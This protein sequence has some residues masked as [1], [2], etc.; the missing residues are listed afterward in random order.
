MEIWKYHFLYDNYMASNLGNIKNIKK[1]EN[2]SGK[3][4]LGEKVVYISYKNNIMTYRFKNFIYEC[5]N[6]IFSSDKYVIY[7]DYNTNNLNIDNLILVNKKELNQFNNTKRNNIISSN[8][9]KNH[10]KYPIGI[11]NESKL[12]YLKGKLK[13]TEI[14]F[15]ETLSELFFLYGSTRLFAKDILYECYNGIIKENH[16]IIYNDFNHKNINIS[17][18]KMIHNNELINYE[19]KVYENKINFKLKDGWKQHP[20]IL[21]YLG[22]EKGE[23][24]SIYKNEIIQGREVGGY[25]IVC[26]YYDTKKINYQ[27]HRFIY[28]CFNGTIKDKLQIDHIDS[29]K[30]NNSI[31]N[32]QAL[33]AKDHVKKTFANNNNIVRKNKKI[34]VYEL[35]NN[36]EI[37]IQIFNSVKDTC[38]KLNISR[39]ICDSKLKNHEKYNNYYIEIFNDKIDNEEWQK[40]NNDIF[41]NY[42]FSNMGRIRLPNKVIT[43]GNINKNFYYSININNKRYNMHY[44]ICLAFNGNPPGIYGKE[45][46]VDHID[47]DPRNNKSINLR[48]ATP[49]EQ[50]NN[51]KSIKKVIAYYLDNNELIGIYANASEA[52]RKI[53]GIFNTSISSV[54][55]G[56]H[57]YHGTINNRKIRWEYEKKTIDI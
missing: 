24:F 54:C 38:S 9:I 12:I 22:N 2:C 8:N 41:K 19:K 36:K 13:N 25:N 23:I 16:S 26:F 49:S 56:E 3:I 37:N 28:E 40:I 21:Y 5:F 17:N 48:W 32:L 6:G 29:N 27:V 46:T 20:N 50:I 18:L 31:N 34:K 42:E 55:R 51:T 39:H 1:K 4:I 43:Y 10:Y 11:N 47:R 14:I 57:K 52:S 35:D 53:D 7:K 33:T 15:D 44:L 45:I 30:N